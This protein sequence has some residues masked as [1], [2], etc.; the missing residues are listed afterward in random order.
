[1]PEPSITEL[2]LEPTG[3]RFRY[4]PGQNIESS[5]DGIHWE[6]AYQLAPLTEADKAYYQKI[7][8]GNPT[9]RETPL[10]GLADPQHGSVIFAMGQEG[11]LV[12]QSSGVWT[13]AALGSYRK[14]AAVSAWSFL[15]TVLNGEIV[16]AGALILLIL[17]FGAYIRRRHWIWTGLIWT[18]WVGWAFLPMIF[19]P[20]LSTQYLASVSIM[21]GYGIAAL[22]LLMSVIGSVRLARV[23]L[24]TFWKLC[25]VALAGGLLYFAPYGL[26][27]FNLLPQYY[28][29]ESLALV[30]GAGMGVFGMM[31]VRNREKIVQK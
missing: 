12:R 4:Q 31:L 14:V 2:T 23:S 24:A 19:S 22:A 16:L 29:A 7:Q 18:G 11:V 5:S 27:A 6:L 10:A 28:V 17:S 20:A 1:M 26:W 21:G 3:L 25:A 8:S 15:T 13:W 30:L 9:M